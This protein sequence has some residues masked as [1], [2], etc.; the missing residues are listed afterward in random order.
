MG[1]QAQ[2]IRRLQ[3]RRLYI[4]VTQFSG[5]QQKAFAPAL[6]MTD[7]SNVATY[8]QA[9]IKGADVVA[10]SAAT[11]VAIAAAPGGGMGGGGN[12]DDY[13]MAGAIFSTLTTTP[14]VAASPDVPRNVVVYVENDSGNPLNMFVGSMVVGITGTFRG[15]AQI[16]DITFAVADDEKAVATANGRVMNGVKPFDTI[17]ALAITNAAAAT[18]KMAIGLGNEFGLPIAGDTGAEADIIKITAAAVDL[19]PTGTYDVTN[20]TVNLSGGSDTADGLDF[21]IIYTVDYDGAAGTIA[22]TA[23]DTLLVSAGVGNPILMEIPAL[24]FMAMLMEA[25]ADDVRHIM[26]MPS[27]MDR[28]NP[29]RVRV[30]WSSEAAAVTTRDITWKFL[31]GALTSETSAIAAPATELNTALVVDAV[32]GTAKVIQK[33]A[34]GVID[35]GTITTSQDVLAFLV[36]MDAFD[37]ALSE[38]KYLLGVEFEYSPK[39]ATQGLPRPRIEASPITP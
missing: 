2:K 11:D 6:T 18:L 24:G 35:R 16:E 34:W 33:T 37:A 38:A 1:N 12:N 31:Y 7:G 32:V 10:D 4:P 5:I 23:V 17:T 20:E 29:I 27:D 22:S 19:D 28:Y 9:D 14:A 3:R 36:E 21:T 15:A 13:I 25:A 30:W 8:S 39:E 26:P